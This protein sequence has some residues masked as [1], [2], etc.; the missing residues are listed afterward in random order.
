MATVRDVLEQAI[1][2]AAFPGCA[3]AWGSSSRAWFAEAGGFTFCPESPRVL[4]ST[5]W[6]LA[7]VSKVVG[8]TTAAMIAERDGKLDLD[9]PVALD[10]PAFG[11]GGKEGV[12]PRELLTHRSGLPAFR[13]LHRTFVDA[14]QALASALATPLAT[15]RGEKTVYSDLGMIAFGALVAKLCG[16]SLDALLL[17][18]AFGPLRMRDTLY[19][20]QGA[21][22]LRC[23]ITEPVEPW[24]IAVRR[25]QGLDPLRGGPYLPDGDYW[26][27]GEVHDPNAM[28]LG[29]VA[30]HAGLFSTTTD[31]ARFCQAMLLA[32]W[33][34]D[35]EQLSRWLRP[36]NDGST[37]A[38]GW[39]TKSAQGSSAGAR[40]SMRSVGHTGYTGTSVWIDLERG[41]FGVLLT[42]RVHPSAENMKISEVR[43][44][45]YDAVARFLGAQT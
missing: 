27:Q 34:F 28:V 44:L 9:R 20:P 25:H 38:L 23:A 7:S 33:P 30:G 12:T 1:R 35:K 2:D 24:R 6:D 16:T 8:C 32:A 11:A 15:P 5:I 43:P 45:F 29:G 37:R 4:R 14:G 17:E 22:R 21:T 36:Q 3:A 39:D 42:N 40:F 31:L 18:R 26:I 10:L 41:W 13:G 19:R